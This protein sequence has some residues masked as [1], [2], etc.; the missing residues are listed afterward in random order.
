[1]NIFVLGIADQCRPMPTNWR[2]LPP[3]IREFWL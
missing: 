2:T 1:M 3:Q